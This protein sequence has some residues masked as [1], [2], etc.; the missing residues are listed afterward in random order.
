MLISHKWYKI[1]IYLQWKANR[2][3]QVSYRMAPI[4]MT[5]SDLECHFSC[6]NLSNSYSSMNMTRI[7]YIV[8]IHEWESICGL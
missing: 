6:L 2:Q 1:D 5:L 4:S 3:S 8:C 7:N